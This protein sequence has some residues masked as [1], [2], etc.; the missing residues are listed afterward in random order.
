M[1]EIIE[2]N[3]YPCLFF[4][5]KEPQGFL[6]LNC[7]K[8]EHLVQISIRGNKSYLEKIDDKIK[9]N[10][11]K[12]EDMINKIESAVELISFSMKREAQHTPLIICRNYKT[13]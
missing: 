6:Y 2:Q 7:D 13:E 11:E 1:T 3:K 4:E 12:L 5:A 10:Q 8:G 9:I